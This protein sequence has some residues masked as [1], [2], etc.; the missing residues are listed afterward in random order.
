VHEKDQNE[1]T[2][3]EDYSP[4]ANLTHHESLATLDNR[5]ER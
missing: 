4:Q 2:E 3:R 5:Q 1:Q